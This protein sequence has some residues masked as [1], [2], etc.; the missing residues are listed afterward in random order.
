M[1][2]LS[3]PTGKSVGPDTT[4]AEKYEPGGGV[5]EIK[6][7]PVPKVAEA[8]RCESKECFQKQLDLLVIERKIIAQN[9]R[10]QPMIQTLDT[11]GNIALGVSPFAGPGTPALVVIGGTLKVLK[12]LVTAGNEA[13]NTRIKGGNQTDA[14]ETFFITTTVEGGTEVVKEVAGQGLSKFIPEGSSDIIT[15]SG[16]LVI[17]VVVDEAPTIGA[18]VVD[19]TFGGGQKVAADTKAFVGDVSRVVSGG[20]F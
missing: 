19:V 11:L 9:Q 15:A 3:V 2:E 20:G 18:G 5:P 16:G 13:K 17:S 8:P 14:L 12:V 1:P 4:P 10:S 7:L 6:P